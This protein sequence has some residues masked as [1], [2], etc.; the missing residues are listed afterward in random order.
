MILKIAPY[1]DAKMKP[2]RSFLS[3]LG[4]YF[5]PITDVTKVTAGYL[6]FA[7]LK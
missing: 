4:P 7:E 2:K 5:K 3:F 6:P 1:L